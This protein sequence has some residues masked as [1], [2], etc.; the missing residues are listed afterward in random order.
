[1]SKTLIYSGTVRPVVTRDPLQA[2]VGK[3]T[4]F[5][6]KV[7]YEKLVLQSWPKV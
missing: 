5:Y 4:F 1:M 6:K 7:V 2:T 3:C